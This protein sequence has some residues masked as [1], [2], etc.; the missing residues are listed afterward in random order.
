MTMAKTDLL[1]CPFCGGAA[2]TDGQQAYRNI[3]TGRA[4]TA[5]AV[6]CTSCGAQHTICRGDV[7]DVEMSEVIELWNRRAGTEITGIRE[8][9]SKVVIDADRDW[10]GNVAGYRQ[11]LV[12]RLTDCGLFVLASRREAQEPV[13][14][15]DAAATL[16]DFENHRG[17]AYPRP[18]VVA[19]DAIGQKKIALYTAPPAPAG[20]VERLA[21][22][23]VLSFLDELA[24]NA[25]PG[26]RKA[27]NPVMIGGS[28]KLYAEGLRAALNG[29]QS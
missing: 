14:F 20:G 27:L 9:F 19:A 11:Y 2:E 5:V 28:A 13:A 29:G 1:P 24:A 18:G 23:P 17:H 12:D 26:R 25:E 3:S 4:E 6:Y 16:A 15:I 21:L 10:N 22:E 8:A 7:P